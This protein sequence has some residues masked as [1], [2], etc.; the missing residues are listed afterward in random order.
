MTGTDCEFKDLH[1]DAL[2]EMADQDVPPVFHT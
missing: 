2:F 1:L